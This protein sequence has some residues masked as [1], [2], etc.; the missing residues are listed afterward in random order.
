MQLQLSAPKIWIAS[1][2]VDFRCG[3]N[4]LSEHVVSALGQRVGD[5]LY[6]FY[7]R[8]R[9][10]LKCLAHHRNGMMLIYKQLDKKKFTLKKGKSGLLEITEEQL[11]WLLAGLDWVGMSSFPEIKY[12][13]YF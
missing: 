9:N 7:N 8:S 1:E 4:R 2:P 13:D 11:S 12:E 6:V 3:I 10:R 5:Q